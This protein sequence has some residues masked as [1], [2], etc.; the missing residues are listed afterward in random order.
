MKKIMF[1]NVFAN[2]DFIIFLILMKAFWITLGMFE[3][4][5]L[6]LRSS[7]T[8]RLYDI[9]SLPFYFLPRICRAERAL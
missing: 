2:K 4:L 6:G 5:A 3:F 8:F 9:F 1:K 7:E